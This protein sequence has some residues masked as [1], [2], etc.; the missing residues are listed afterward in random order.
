MIQISKM[1][2]QTFF[3]KSVFIKQQ[4]TKIALLLKSGK[5]IANKVE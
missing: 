4:Q 2:L 5:K 3:H 1:K